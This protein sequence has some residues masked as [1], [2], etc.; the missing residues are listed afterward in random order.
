MAVAAMHDP[1]AYMMLTYPHSQNVPQYDN[2]IN[3][4]NDNANLR[5]VTTK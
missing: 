5:I 4:N 1:T 3:G 2:D